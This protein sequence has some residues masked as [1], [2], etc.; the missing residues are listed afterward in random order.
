[1]DIYSKRHTWKI[2]LGL[3]ALIILIITSFYSNFLAQKLAEK[4]SKEV[5]YFS[6]AIES[7]TAF[8]DPSELNED[9]HPLSDT[10]LRSYSIPTILESEEGFLQGYN[11]RNEFETDQEYLENEKQKLLRQGV[12][13]I[14]GSGYHK[15][16]YFKNTR[17]YTIIKYFPLV[18][19]LL[20]SSFVILGYFLFST[21]RRA[22]Q[23][24]VWA[25]MAKETAHQ[26]GTP[27]S[28]II[29]WIEHLKESS[30]DN[31]DH[32][33]II[34][35]LEKDVDRLGLIA[36]RF[37]KIGSAP[38]LVKIN[39]VKELETCKNYMAKRASRRISFNFPTPDSEPYY[40][41]INQHLFEWVVENL[42]RNSLDAMGGEGSISAK[43]YRDNQW[44]CVDLIDT[45]K[46]IPTSKFNTVFQP[47]FST[48]KRG[49]GLGL[50]LARRIIENYHRGKIFVKNSKLNE[51]TT[52]TIKLPQA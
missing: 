45:G 6:Q 36:D 23:N 22:E 28:A 30:T 4:E 19:I 38:K 11:L 51:G 7:V 13:P 35:E 16:I 33:E 2:I 49:W 40:V 29:A 24:R 1:M 15:F 52:F 48:K 8:D 46:G 25:G 20:I 9:F 17:L 21:S 37:S 43:L 42:M 12:K 31:Q 44:I 14:E 32:L 39:L 34:S 26:L 27:I 47:G 18:Q 3:I 5:Y 41:M 10:I 50:S